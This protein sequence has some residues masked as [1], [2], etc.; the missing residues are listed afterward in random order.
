MNASPSQDSI[1]TTKLLFPMEARFVT[2]N[3]RSYLQ[4]KRYNFIATLNNCPKISELYF[5][6]DENWIQALQV[7]EHVSTGE[8]IVP[9]QLTIFCFRELRL[10]A[11]LLFSCCTNQGYCHLRT[12]MEA[13]TQAQKII[14][15]PS[16]GNIWLNREENRAEYDKYFKGRVKDNL[17]PASSGLAQLHVVWEMLCNAGAHSN[18]TSLGISSSIKASDGDVLWKLEFFEVDQG[19]V[20]KNLLLMIMCQLEMFKHTFNVFHERL[21]LHPHM[22]QNLQLHLARFAELNKHYMVNA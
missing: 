2:G 8:W 13:F 5:Q 22:L 19:E 1:D 6:A 3:Y 16:L 9:T 18:V 4:A 14:R 10:A 17:F 12:A 20:T 15:E 7:L 11:E 21:S